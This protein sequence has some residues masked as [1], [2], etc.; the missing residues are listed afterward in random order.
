MR[1]VNKE[2]NIT[3]R[4]NFFKGM[5]AGAAAAAVSSALGGLK[6]ASAAPAPP[7]QAEDESVDEIR[8][9]NRKMMI[10]VFCHFLPEKYL[11][12]YG[13]RNPKILNSPEGRSLATTN[14]DYRLRLIDRYPGVFQVLTVANPPPDAFVSPEYTPELA[15]IANDEF[16]ELVDKYPDKFLGAVACLPMNNL[17]AAVK[18]ADRALTKLRLKGIQIATRINKELIDPKQFK[19]LWER[20]NRSGLPIWIHP[21]TD[22]TQEPDGGRLSW[23]YD[24]ATVM[25]RIVYAGIFNDYP[26][27]KFI[28]HHCGSMIPTFANRVGRMDDFRKF[29]ADTALYGNTDGLMLGYK[30]FGP[31]HILFGTDAGPVGYTWRTIVSVERMDIPEADK[32]KIFTDN[33]VNLLRLSI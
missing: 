27:L 30:F 33:A 10:D 15:Q 14:L 31:D 28:A 21:Y 32:R 17:D 11:A 22:Q 19:P 18:E 16:A 5:A 4:R 2:E 13:K 12:A 1:F 3:T 29:Y 20:M 9:G 23:P 6:A 7:Q 26:N 8:Y 24:T 25:Y